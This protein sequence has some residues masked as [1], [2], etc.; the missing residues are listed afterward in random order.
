MEGVAKVIRDSGHTVFTPT[1]AGNGPGDS[2][3]AHLDD[4]I[5][6]I[7]EYFKKNNISDAILYSHSYGGIPATGAADRLEKGAV[8]RLVYH[9]AFVPNNGESREDM[10]PPAFNELFKVIKQPDGGLALPTR[11]GEKH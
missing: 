9:S 5:D 4:A 10:N 3:S 7:V 8:K 6:S 2:K 11:S 1:L